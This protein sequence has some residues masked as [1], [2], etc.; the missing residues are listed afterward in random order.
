M[1]LPRATP[2]AAVAVV[3]TAL[4]GLARGRLRRL[5][6]L[7]KPALMP[8][9]AWWAVGRHGPAQRAMLRRTGAAMVL[10][11]VGDVALLR[12][13]DDAFLV[14]LGGFLGAHLAY[15]SAF[16]GRTRRWGPGT[17]RRVGPVAATAAVTVPV[18]VTRAGPRL[19]GPVAAYGLAIAAMAAAAT[20]LD[21]SVV[22]ASARRRIAAGAVCFMVSDALLGARRFLLPRSSGSRGDDLGEVVGEAAVM[23]TYTLAQWLLV[24]GV[25]RATQAP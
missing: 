20:T 8:S 16:A 21:A 1:P 17:A 2:Y 10:S 15:G 18:L 9:L 23:A 11:A 7:T 19:G 24:D 5:R 14:G 25:V 13:D 12:E 4:A 6:L 3:D 22:P